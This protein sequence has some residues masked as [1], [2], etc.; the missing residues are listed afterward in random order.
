VE[1]VET[2]EL[3]L[4]TGIDRGLQVRHIA[5]LDAKVV[6]VRKKRRAVHSQAPG[7]S[8]GPTHAALACTLLTSMQG[9]SDEVIRALTKSA[10]SKKLFESAHC[11]P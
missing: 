5:S 4:R 3:R 1:S 8:K 2:V 11:L 6:H 10:H 9:N 7:V